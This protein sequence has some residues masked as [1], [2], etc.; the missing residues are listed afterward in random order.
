MKILGLGTDI[1]NLARIKKIQLK[2]G[3]KFVNKVLTKNEIKIEKKKFQTVR[4]ETLAKRFAAKEAISKA[5]GFGMSK[6]IYFKNIEIINNKHGKPCVNLYG[7]TK[8]ILKK[9]SKKYDIFLTLSDDKP[10]SVAT[11]LITSK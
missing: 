1:I 8:A 4:S 6:G 11:A 5:I 10:W 9:I 7:K 2:Y 3:Q